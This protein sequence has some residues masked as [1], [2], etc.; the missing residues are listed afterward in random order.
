MSPISGESQPD[1]T[2]VSLTEAQ[3]ANTPEVGEGTTTTAS[4]AEPD[5]TPARRF[6]VQQLVAGVLA[7]AGTSIGLLALDQTTAGLLAALAAF[8]G[9]VGASVLN[10]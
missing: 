1:D 9:A 3:A 2:H 4:W 5:G 7:A 6:S 8:L 10:A